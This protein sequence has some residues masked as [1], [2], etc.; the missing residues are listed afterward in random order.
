MDLLLAAFPPELGPWL[1]A[2][3]KGWRSACTGIGALTAAVTTARLI[4]EQRPGRVL[5][6]GTCGAYDDRMAVGALLAASQAIATSAPELRRAAFR[7]ASERTRWDATWH[8]PW[9]SHPVVVPPAITKDPSDALLLAALGPVEHL[10]LTGIFAACHLA[11]VPCAAL[12]VV[13]N[14]V[15]PEAHTQWQRHHASVSARL[16]EVLGSWL[17]GS[18]MAN[19]LPDEGGSSR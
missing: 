3:P 10:E 17:Q 19:P 16:R 9:P 4:L 18:T 1:K 8:L 6:L 12:L 5:F 14:A 13:A 7:P 2:P 15:G 11:D